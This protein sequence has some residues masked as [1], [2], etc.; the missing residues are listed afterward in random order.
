MSG[1][2]VAYHLRPNKAIDRQIFLELLTRFHGFRPIHD[3]TYVGFGGPFLEDFRAVEGFFGVRRMIS[4]EGDAAVLDRQRFNLP[5]T[6]VDCRKQ[7]SG[8][9]ISTY[10]AE[11][12]GSA[13]VWLDYAAANERRAQLGEFQSLLTKMRGYDI[14]KITMNANPATLPLRNGAGKDDMRARYEAAEQQ[15]GDLWLPTVTEAQMTRKEFPRVVLGCALRAANRALPPG[16][17]L[18]FVPLTS[19]VYADSEHRMLT[20]TGAMI[21]RT[22]VARMRSALRLRKWELAY[23]EDRAPIEI[24]TP[25]LST[26]ERIFFEQ[27]L[28]KYRRSLSKRCDFQVAV[29]S[30]EST[31]L[32][33]S[34][35]RFHRYYPHFARIVP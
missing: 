18:D 35:A 19:F 6:N 14:I 4:L 11:E 2:Q 27:L 17:D 23:R 8:E 13:I 10:A 9:F 29:N 33:Q 1:G 24:V 31:E 3:Y 21:P 7:L 16:R 28:P 30:R 15:L 20:L 12:I 25:M 5:F 26:R 34:F 22:D 32:L